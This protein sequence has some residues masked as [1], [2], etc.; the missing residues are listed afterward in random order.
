[1]IYPGFELKFKLM[2]REKT[3]SSLE[4]IKNLVGQ[5]WTAEELE[6]GVSEAKVANF[7][8]IPP[9]NLAYWRKNGYFTPP[10]KVGACSR[11][12]SPCAFDVWQIVRA[13][14]VAAL[15]QAGYEREEIREELRESR[16]WEKHRDAIVRFLNQRIQ[17]I[18][19]P[20]V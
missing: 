15:T 7:L 10:R 5:L 8:G 2:E 20:E 1:M 17:E 6:E 16:Y 9:S 4:E 19:L 12:P 18:N 13:A 3:P 14:L 11:S